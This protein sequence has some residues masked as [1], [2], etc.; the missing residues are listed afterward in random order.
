[1]TAFKASSWYPPVH[2][3]C[4]CRWQFLP[5]TVDRIFG[6]C[7]QTGR[8]KPMSL[9]IIALFYGE[10]IDAVVPKCGL[11]GFESALDVFD[12]SELEA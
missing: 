5:V 10:M 1:M 11:Q 9:C 3:S 4:S 8:I 12:F 6:A 7:I 2:S